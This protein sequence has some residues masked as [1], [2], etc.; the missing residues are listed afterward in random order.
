MDWSQ[1][2]SMLGGSG[3]GGSGTPIYTSASTGPITFGSPGSD[4]VT[5]MAGIAGAVVVL[6][7]LIA[8]VFHK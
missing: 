4:Q 8:I 6:I 1:Y 5:L 7:V 2:T 3:G